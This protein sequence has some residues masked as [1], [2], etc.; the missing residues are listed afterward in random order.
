MNACNMVKAEELLAGYPLPTPLRR[1]LQADLRDALDRGFH[2]DL[3][4]LG[5][6]LKLL[7]GGDRPARGH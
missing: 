6:N 3:E 4:Q 2:I 7:V 1:T 5:T